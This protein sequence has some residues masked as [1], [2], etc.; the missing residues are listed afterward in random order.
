MDTPKPTPEPDPRDAEIERLR[1][2]AEPIWPRSPEQAAFEDA[3][4]R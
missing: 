3:V 4:D 1:E 2:L